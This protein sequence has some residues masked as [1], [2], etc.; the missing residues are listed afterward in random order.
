MK[1]IRKDIKKA[2]FKSDERVEKVAQKSYNPKNCMR[3][4]FF[5]RPIVHI[6][7]WRLF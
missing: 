2:N 5:N 3:V 6:R 7:A 1:N 4:L